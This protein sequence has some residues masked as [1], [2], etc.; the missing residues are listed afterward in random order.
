MII[1]DI[2][3][4]SI[5]IIVAVVISALIIINLID[6]KKN[7]KPEVKRK[8]FHMS[9][10]IAMLLLPYIFENVISV[11]VLGCLAILGMFILKYSRLKNN[12][13][14]TLYS[15]ERKSLGEFYF[16]ISIFLIFWLSG[17]NKVLYSVPILILT[18]ADSTAA[19]IGKSYAKKNLAE[20][21][22]DAKSIEGS[23]MFFITAFIIVLVPLLLYTTVGREELLIISAIIGLNVAMVEMISHSGDDNILIPM[24]TYAFLSNL[25]GQELETLRINI[26]I[27]VAIF[28]LVTIANRV[29]AWS[30]LA[31]V[32][33]AVVGY[34]SAMLY[35]IY[36]IFAPAM[37]FLTVMN[38]PKRCE[39]EKELKYDARIIETN[40][41]IGLTICILASLTNMRKELFMLYNLVYSMHLVIN[42]C[43]RFKYYFNCNEPT[44]LLYSYTKGLVFIFLPGIF[45]GYLVFGEV[46]KTGLLI[47]MCSMLLLSGTAVLIQRR[48][49]KEEVVSIENGYTHMAIALV[50]TIA[51]Y[52]IQYFS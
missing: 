50:L 37:L 10:G 23:F 51:T 49:Q 12:L 26:L 13:G 17:G 7:L 5:L 3:I 21:N 44:S 35:G 31:L 45:L 30:K 29:K 11:G 39:K 43:V 18:F 48:N 36:A 25:M 46:I 42:S 14:K 16:I 52:I 38:F 33:T 34:L 22:E 32:E 40:I 24:T 9:M 20:M 41:I 8:A 1:K 2:E 28:I 27:I 6:K 15:I 4:T 47:V 19:L